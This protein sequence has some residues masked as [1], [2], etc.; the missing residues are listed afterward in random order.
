MLELSAHF[1]RK[2]KQARV[3]RALTQA[4]AA[5]RAGINRKL[6]IRI[7]K[8]ENVGIDEV[9]KLAHALGFTLTLSETIRPTWENAREI[10]LS[11]DDD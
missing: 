2:L 5:S 6:I 9:H 11:D 4:Q 7:E 8:G 10:F 1:G 3:E